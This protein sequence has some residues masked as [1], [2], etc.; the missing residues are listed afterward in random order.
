[1]LHADWPLKFWQRLAGVLN[2]VVPIMHL[3]FFIVQLALKRDRR[4]FFLQDLF[5]P[6]P[7]P[8]RQMVTGMAFM[9]ATPGLVG[10]TDN[11]MAVQRDV[12]LPILHPELVAGIC[13]KVAFPNH[14]LCTDNMG[15]LCNIRRLKLPIRWLNLP[16]I[17]L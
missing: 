8:Y 15:V 3:P 14:V 12:R 2:F 11:R 16:F 4:V 13:G 5:R 17:I 9:D 10:I 1:M 7:V 6:Q